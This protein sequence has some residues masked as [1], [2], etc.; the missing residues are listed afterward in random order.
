M[1]NAS[2]AFGGA[3]GIVVNEVVGGSLSISGLGSLGTLGVMGVVSFGSLV[4]MAGVI[5]FCMP[6]WADAYESMGY[7]DLA[8]WYRTHNIFDILEN[9]FRINTTYAEKYF[10]MTVDFIKNQKIT[11]NDVIRALILLSDKKQ[12]AVILGSNFGS[13]LIK[14]FKNSQGDPNGTGE[15]DPIE[16]GKYWDKTKL[17]LLKAWNDANY[18]EVVKLSI[19]L[20]TTALSGG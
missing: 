3:F 19:V 10:G 9:S 6:F 12:I 2:I 18:G 17:K 13:N 15:G 1:G 7:H 14:G 8:E 5:Q 11:Y 20:G 16:I 4:F